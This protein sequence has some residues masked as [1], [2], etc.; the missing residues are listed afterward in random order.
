[1]TQSE[2][3]ALDSEH[4]EEMDLLRRVL[5]PLGEER[6]SEVLEMVQ[7]YLAHVSPVLG[8]AGFTEPGDPV[9]GQP[10]ETPDAVTWE[11]GRESPLDKTRTVFAIFDWPE[12]RCLVAY[13]FAALQAEGDDRVIG[14]YYRE[15]IYR[16]RYSWG[17]LTLDALY[18]DL[19]YHLD[20]DVAPEPGSKNGVKG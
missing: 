4:A 14:M 13:S 11:V 10:G 17:P 20:V 7:K 9:S 2:A 5:M 18:N 1:M 8:A 6:C 16:P 3:G 12:M 15:K 19:T